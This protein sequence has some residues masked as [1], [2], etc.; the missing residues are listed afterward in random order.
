MFDSSLYDL[1]DSNSENFDLKEEQ[2][3]E[4]KPEDI[5]KV[6]FLRH[7]HAIKSQAMWTV[8]GE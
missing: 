6:Q 5:Y 1:M 8:T 7:D 4:R 3:F 2:L